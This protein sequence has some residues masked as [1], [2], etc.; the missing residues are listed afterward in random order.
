MD[1]RRGGRDD[2]EALVALEARCFDLDRL[3][4][5]NFRYLLSRANALTLVASEG[6]R[7][8]G[9][10]MLL[11]NTGT[12]LARLYSVAVDPSSRGLGIGATLLG[13]SE[14]AAREHDCVSMRLEVRSD[15]EAAI[16][17]YDK[18][19]YRRFGVIEDYYE[20]HRAALRFEKFIVP[21]LEPNLVNV[22]FY[23]QTLD[24]TCGPSALM[25]AMKALDPSLDLDRKLEL[26]IWRE[27]TSIFMTAGHG[28]CGPYGLALSAFH[29]GFSVEIFIN[30]E[31]ALFTRS[32]R[33]EEKKEVI[34]LVQEDMLEEIRTHPIALHY[35]TPG[36]SE[37]QDRVEAGL[38][39]LVLI[40]SRRIYH[41]NSPHW[42]VVTGFDDRFIY[43]H[44]SFVDLAAHKSA[45]DSI[46][47]PI[48][49]KDF[50]RM[51]RYGKSGLKAALFVGGA[52]SG[53]APK[54]SDRGGGR[55]RNKRL[56]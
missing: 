29:R 30:D 44:D 27:S 28:G 45:T 43:V 21:H 46:N 14:E 42:V 20:D 48:L 8:L 7:M 19:G 56:D 6:G 50:E 2:L 55:R 36:M 4:R 25:M 31:G 40:S 5:R 34:R 35:G 32:V 54:K 23:M 12:S 18:S 24:F 13:A 47:M 39:P 33:S 53:R 51:A 37:I 38:I 41:E 9:Y 1:I 15:N 10:A 26:R 22:P 52:P 16:R 17:L 11:F 3:S 49:K